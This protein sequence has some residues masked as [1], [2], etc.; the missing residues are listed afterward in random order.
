MH[1]VGGFQ[2]PAPV[3]IAGLKVLEEAFFPK[4]SR[5]EIDRTEE[6]FVGGDFAGGHKFLRKKRVAVY[7]DAFVGREGA[8]R[9]NRVRAWGKAAEAPE[10]CLGLVNM[11]RCAV[12]IFTGGCEGVHDL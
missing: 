6:S 11:G 9:V 1:M 12:R 8:H 4:V 7:G 2:Y 10:A 3:G 5:R